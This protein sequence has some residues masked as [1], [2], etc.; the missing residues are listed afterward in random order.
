MAE[1]RK[2]K[3]VLL[4]LFDEK[5]HEHLL[6]KGRCVSLRVFYLKGISVRTENNVTSLSSKSY[7][8]ANLMKI[9]SLLREVRSGYILCLTVLH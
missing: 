6:S 5:R 1:F 7:L 3:E 2:Q 4:C 9:L 8:G